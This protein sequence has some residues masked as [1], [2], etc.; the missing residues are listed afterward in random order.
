VLQRGED[1]SVTRRPG[2]PRG[3]RLMGVVAAFGEVAVIGAHE[4][5][6]DTLHR[7]VVER[8]YGVVEDGELRV[9]PQPTV[10]IFQTLSQFRRRLLQRLPK[11]SCESRQSFCDTYTGRKKTIYE[12]AAA[13]LENEPVN[14]RDARGKLFG[15]AEK[16]NFSA[17]PD[18][19][20]RII[21]PRD[22]RY[23]V[24]VGRR[25]KFVEHRIYHAIGSVFGGVT[26]CKGLN[27]DQRGK[28]LH[29]KFSQFYEPVVFGLDA[30]RF[31][32]HISV[33]ALKFEHS[34]YNAVF[35]DKELARLLK[36]Q[37]VNKGRGYCPDGVL[38]FVKLGTRGSGDMNTALGNCLI[39]C[40]MVWTYARHKGIK[41]SLANDGDDCAVFMESWDAPQFESGLREWFL[42]LGFTMKVDYVTS[43]FEEVE[44]CQC[45][46]VFIDGI[47]RM[48]RNPT[49][50]LSGDICSLKIRTEKE[51]KTHL[52]AVGVCGGVISAGVPVYQSYYL[53]MR[54]VG[55]VER[56]R[57]I[58]ER[59]VEMGN[60]GFTRMA[61][62]TD[63]TLSVQLKPISP[64]TRVSYWKAFGI[65]PDRQIA[66]ERHYQ[67]VELGKGVAPHESIGSAFT[68]TSAP[69]S[70]KFCLYGKI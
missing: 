57:R 59:D 37:L 48:I 56:A 13:T 54:E 8:V 50:A 43:V 65:T 26:V 3:P 66:L 61:L 69:T 45:H 49:K 38:D 34:I 40:A 7:G 27:P 5:D 22:P 28:L 58:L 15:K 10:N 19:P 21:F 51:A 36:W 6:V 42:T 23:N 14:Q 55:N 44:F 63:S 32:Q 47:P 68:R 16:T 25:L 39:M 12:A 62:E 29:K 35:E 41:V 67:N 2:K 30:K 1:L 33:P 24:E 53:R 64:Q 46:P 31:D 11:A 52:G 4:R 9:V 17:K 20:V 70:Q 18:A 60:Y